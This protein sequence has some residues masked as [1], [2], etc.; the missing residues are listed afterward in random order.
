MN[1][2]NCYLED[3]TFCDD[4][5]RYY[6]WKEAMNVCPAG[7]HLPDDAGWRDFQKDEKSVDWKGL[8]RGGCRDWDPTVIRTARDITGPR[9]PHKGTAR[10][11]EF[12]SR[13]KSVSRDDC[14]MK[15]GMLVR[16]VQNAD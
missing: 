13:S 15:M 2:K 12:S 10:G 4:Y 5:G 9:V 14:D 6:T 11:W 16:C 1:A 7:W 8:G 3:S